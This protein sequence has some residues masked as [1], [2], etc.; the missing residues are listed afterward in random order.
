MISKMRKGSAVVDVAIDQGGCTETSHPT[1]FE[2]P[3]FTTD[4]VTQYC[5]ANMPGCVSRT[6][7]FALTNATF[8][9]ILKLANLGFTRA[10]DQDSSLKKGLNLFRGSLTNS[11]VAEAL[12]I[13][14]TPY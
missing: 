10:L 3:V 1:T 4:G 6:S 11:K 5:V 7:T 14:Y 2:N 12:G 9:Y 8:P 13:D